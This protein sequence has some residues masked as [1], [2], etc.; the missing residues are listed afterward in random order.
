M[1]YRQLKPFYP[2]DMGKDKGYCLRNVAKGYH[3]Y[4]SPNPSQSAKQDME[5]NKAK[6][7]LHPLSTLPTNVSVPVYLDTTSQYE[8]IEVSDKGV[9]WSDG[10]QVKKPLNAF[11]WGE[12]CNGYRI[13]EW[14]KDP[15]PTNFLP[16][17]GWWGRYDVDPRVG[18]LASFMRS[19]F[20]AYTPKAAL[21][22]TYGD[23]LWKS[24]KEFQ[25][26]TGL[27][28]DGNTGTITYNE[29]K[30]YGFKG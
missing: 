11:G 30:K 10:K 1:S 8:H 18:R 17:K 19:T 27:Q 25:R 4:P 6:G 26:R 12:W 24:I 7:T 23:N 29:L 9:F 5:I 14:V 13:V 22:N 16:A 21:G 28:A 2:Q 20:P 15:E 3:I